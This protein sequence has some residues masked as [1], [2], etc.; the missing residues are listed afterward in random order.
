[1]TIFVIFSLFGI[2]ILYGTEGCQNEESNVS[3]NNVSHH[4]NYDQELKQYCIVLENC[5]TLE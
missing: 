1:M 4:Y 3:I 2:H 5:Y